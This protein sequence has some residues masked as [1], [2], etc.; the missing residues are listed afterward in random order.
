MLADIFLRPSTNT[1]R[2]ISLRYTHLGESAEVVVRR[3]K[4]QGTLKSRTF[5][6]C[7]RVSARESPRVEVK[8]APKSPTMKPTFVE[9][10]AVR[11]RVDS[12]W[13]PRQY[14]FGVLPFGMSSLCDTPQRH[15]ELRYPQPWHYPC[16]WRCSSLTGIHRV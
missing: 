14:G 4:C 5:L 9:R 11:R 10:L 16:R 8:G 6:T 7:C 3:M 15:D 1:S 13:K 2:G 12:T